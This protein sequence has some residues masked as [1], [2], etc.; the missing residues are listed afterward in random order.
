MISIQ[1]RH[2]EEPPPLRDV[3]MPPLHDDDGPPAWLDDVPP[4]P[5]P[6]TAPETEE[7]EAFTGMSP[8]TISE[9]AH[10]CLR[11]DFGLE[12]FRE[13]QLDVI[14][15]VLSG[16]SALAVM[17]TGAGK[18]LC[19][20]LPAMLVPGVTI[21]VSPLIALMKD[22]VDSLQARG[23]PATFINSTLSL[24]EQRE[25]IWRI[26]HGLEKMV[27]VAPER[28]RS[29]M[30]WD[31]LG[32]IQVNL[33]AVDE[34]HCISSWGHDFRPDYLELGKVRARLGYP[35]TIALTATAT[36]K[37]QH[38]IRRLLGV[39]G[40]CDTFVS[41]FERSNLFLEVYKASGKGAKRN[42]IR[43]MKALLEHM[44][45]TGIVYCSTRKAVEEIGREL[46]KS[47]FN[48]DVYHGGL[49]DSQREEVQDRFMAGEIRILVATNAFGMGVDKGDIRT[50]VHFQMPASLEAY[51]QEAGRAGR[52]GEPSHCLFL[53]SYADRRVPDFFVQSAHPEQDVVIDVWNFL[54]R[55]GRGVH[56]FTASQI[57]RRLTNRTSDMAVGS[58]LNMLSRAGHVA[59]P[60]QTGQAGVEVLDTCLA[61]QLRIDWRELSDRRKFEEEKLKKVIFY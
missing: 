46:D 15:T 28:F 10:T 33:I 43:R 42:K 50:I 49:S 1:D 27:F 7:V 56:M 58:A 59:L 32:K 54:R 21:V 51:Y 41:G 23:L 20:Q 2:T 22:Q 18:S 61:R 24:S 14:A 8:D 55:L 53:Y 37:V 39:E 48:A 17:P 57:A 12:S 45:G 35:V 13:G 44:G 19:Y 47:G 3:D 16:R 40:E 9:A 30:F 52:D 6:Q 26:R 31:L 60:S 38:D 36:P 34:A 29:D 25:R 5:E 4:P 11:D